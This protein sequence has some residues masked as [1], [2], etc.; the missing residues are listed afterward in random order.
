[1]IEVPVKPMTGANSAMGKGAPIPPGIMRRFA[2]ALEHVSHPDEAMD[3]LH[4]AV[5]SIGFSSVD[6][7]YLP[8]ARGIDGSWMPPPLRTRN[9]PRGWDRKWDRHRAH[10]PYYR[11]C[12]RGTEI[13]D[14]I[15]V[16]RDVHRLKPEERDCLN[17]IADVGFAFG[18]TVPI[19]MPGSGFAF[20]TALAEPDDWAQQV[21]RTKDVLF[22]ISHY[23]NNDMIARFR[24]FRGSSPGEL[25]AREL[26][27]LS[28]CAKGKTIQET[29]MILDISMETV[30]VYLKRCKLKL[31]ASTC[32]HAVAKAIYLGM[33]TASS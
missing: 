17:Y 33:I 22:L 18:L 21:A 29:A 9:F 30:R 2:L 27:C 6:Y 7:A 31:D 23:F 14:W 4:D 16:Q 15:D 3:V 32:S 5:A 28:W 19:H 1:M 26:E 8:A 24:D 20:V 11:A 10:D 12:F 13:V 25:S